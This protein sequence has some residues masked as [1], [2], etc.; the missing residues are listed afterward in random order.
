VA[1]RPVGALAASSSDFTISSQ[2]QQQ[3]VDVDVSPMIDVV[4]R[5]WK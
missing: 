3:Q 2:P 1:E 5:Y 4:L